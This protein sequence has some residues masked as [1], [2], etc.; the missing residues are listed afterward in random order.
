M[1]QYNRSFFKFYIKY[2]LFLNLYAY[3]FEFIESFAFL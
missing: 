2:R 1:I 3:Y